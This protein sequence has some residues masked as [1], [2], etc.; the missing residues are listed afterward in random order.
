MK[1]NFLLNQFERILAVKKCVN[2]LSIKGIFGILLISLTFQ[3][4][5]S[6]AWAI[7][8]RSGPEWTFTNEKLIELGRQREQN[9]NSQGALQHDNYQKE[10]LNK[11]INVIKDKCNQC[12]FKEKNTSFEVQF[13][14]GLHF[15][16]AKDPWILEVTGSPMTLSELTK[17]QDL[18]Q[19]LI[20]D[21]AAEVN[22]KPHSRIGGGHIHLEISSFFNN[23]R[24]L[25][26]NFIVDL[27]N[28]P[29][30]FLGGIGFDLLNA[31]P[32]AI[33]NDR[34]RRKFAE[35]VNK[36]D[37]GQM[38][39]PDFIDEIERDVYNHTFYPQYPHQRAYPQK[40]QAVNLSH[41][42]TIEIRGIRPEISANHYIKLITLFQNRIDYLKK[43]QTPILYNNK[44]YSSQVNTTTERSLEL[45]TTVIPSEIIEKVTRDYV[46]GSNLKWPDYEELMTEDLKL[47]RKTAISCDQLF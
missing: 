34:Q 20:W 30:L 10:L 6:F 31:P 32:I 47:R 37:Q 15:T 21:T 28:H 4:A 13:A 46:E 27:A 43:I 25:F 22:L 16:I 2:E 39:I 40:Y 35:L 44:N 11:W 1:K 41:S 36:F 12:I 38:S 24:L 9:R 26:R 29:E 3:L 33:L 14:P 18:L 42:F 45:H 19:H 5:I 8:G 7:N 17:N 23:D